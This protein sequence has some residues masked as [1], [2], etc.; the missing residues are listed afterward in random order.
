MYKHLIFYLIFVLSVFIFVFSFFVVN[1][2]EQT[3]I[4]WKAPME[5]C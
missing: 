1:S 2:F 3:T 5:M 4:Q